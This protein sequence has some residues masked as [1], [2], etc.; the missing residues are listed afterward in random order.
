MA[1]RGATQAAFAPDHAHGMAPAVVA[2]GRAHR[3]AAHGLC[4]PA[5]G[6]RHGGAGF[7][8]GPPAP[9]RSLATSTRAPNLRGVRAA[10]DA[11][12]PTGRGSE[13]PGAATP[14]RMAVAA[15]WHAG[16]RLGAR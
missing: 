1:G 12:R 4:R 7:R 13:A 8:L 16:G 6:W 5:V 2:T 15:G 14:Y 9:A 3:A 10:P 11:D